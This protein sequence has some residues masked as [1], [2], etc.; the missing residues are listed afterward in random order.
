MSAHPSPSAALDAAASGVATSSPS[1]HPLP[2]A[3]AG[4]R[5]LIPHAGNRI[6][7]YLS[8]RCLRPGAQ[9]CRPLVLV[10]SVNA[11]ASAAEVRPLFDHYAA[12]RP[13]LA[14]ELPGFGSSDRVD[15]P[16][17]PALMSSAVLSALDYLRSLGFADAPDV[18]AVSLSCEFVAR[19]ALRQPQRFHSVCLV[20]PT[21]LAGGRDEAYDEGRSKKKPWLLA[22]LRFPLWSWL[23]FRA[24]TSRPSLRWF[25]QRSW[26]SKRIDETLLDYDA[27][28]ALQPGARHAPLAFLSGALFTR[29]V[30]QLYRRLRVPVWLAHGTRG[31]FADFDGVERLGPLAHWRRDRFDTGAL[32]YF[33]ALRDFGLL[34][35]A[36]LTR[37]E[38]KT[39][40]ARQAVRA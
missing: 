11:A 22:V 9:A 5:Q 15:R 17:G 38:T 10:H 14:L 40:R 21:G 27:E 29:G 7:V 32:P 13:V 26:G 31:E 16:Y 6:A 25:L 4:E 35:D 30:A 28:T 3:L 12:R 37:V 33:E 2:A 18:L 24:L 8:A 19:A 1:T 39:A 23:L 36:F 34:Y 20:S